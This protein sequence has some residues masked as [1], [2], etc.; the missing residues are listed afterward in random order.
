MTFGLKIKLL[1]SLLAL[2]FY[3]G[4]IQA[5]VKLMPLK[6]LADGYLGLQDDK[7]PVFNSIKKGNACL[8]GNHWCYANKPQ[9]PPNYIYD[10]GLNDDLLLV[11][12]D[13]QLVMIKKEAIKQVDGV[14]KLSN[15]KG[16]FAL[17]SH[18]LAENIEKLSV[19]PFQTSAINVAH[20]YTEITAIHTS[21][22]VD[23][24]PIDHNDP[25]DFNFTVTINVDGGIATMNF[26]QMLT[27]IQEQL[28]SREGFITG[29]DGILAN[30]GGDCN[31]L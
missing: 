8:F 31:E 19:L 30:C 22:S 28:E 20:R 4:S 17:S 16:Y 1:P 3:A 25:N 2:C 23:D 21:Q 26:L 11:I 12:I 5:E 29:F 13:S 10:G 9:L 18:R 14:Y 6:K 7:V 15:L 27:Y 24:E